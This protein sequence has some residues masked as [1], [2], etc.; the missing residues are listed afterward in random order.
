MFLYSLDSVSEYYG[1]RMTMLPPCVEISYYHSRGKSVI[2]RVLRLKSIIGRV[3]I[4]AGYIISLLNLSWE[5]FYPPLEKQ[6]GRHR[7]FVDGHPGVL[8]ILRLFHIYGKLNVFMRD[9]LNKYICSL[10]ICEPEACLIFKN[11]IATMGIFLDS[12][13]GLLN[14]LRP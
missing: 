1:L 3:L 5:Y 6:D 12:Q 11:K 7:H 13:Q 9:I 8:Y 10:Q 14:I 2:G 4:V